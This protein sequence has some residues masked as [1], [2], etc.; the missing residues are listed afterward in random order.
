MSALRATPSTVGSSRRGFPHTV[1]DGCGSS[2]CPRSTAGFGRAAPTKAPAHPSGC[3][4]SAAPYAQAEDRGTVMVDAGFTIPI[5]HRI[6]LPGHFDVP[7]TLEDARPVGNSYKSATAVLSELRSSCLYLHHD[8][9]RYCFKKDPEVDLDSGFLMVPASLPDETPAP[10]PTSGQPQPAAGPSG[11]TAGTGEHSCRDP[12]RRRLHG[13]YE[14]HPA[15]GPS[16]VYGDAGP[17]LQGLPR[18]RQPGGQ[19]GRR[20]DHHSRRGNL[21]AG[22][23][24]LLAPKRR[25]RA[26]G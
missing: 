10:G 17:G 26:L 22:L 20:E 5:G 12:G 15:D 24:R 16:C 11:S 1:S 4:R 2:S 13:F 8:G 7:V 25:R 19:V 9:V 3:G 6:T 18:D 23:R 21:R 14:R